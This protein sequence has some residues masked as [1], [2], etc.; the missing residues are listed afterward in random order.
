MK[1][2]VTGAT[3]FVGRHLCQHLRLSQYE[4]VPLDRTTGV[5]IL[6]AEALH[7]FLDDAAPDAIVH[8]AGDADVGGSWRNPRSTFEANAVGTLAVL[9]AARRGTTGRVVVASSA[10]VYGTVIA[11]DLPIGE[12]T[13]LRPTSPYAASKAAAEVVA[14][15]MARSWNCDVVVTRAFN[16]IGPGQSERFVAPSIAMSIARVERDAEARTGFRATN[17]DAPDSGPHAERHASHG[18]RPGRDAPAAV[19]VGNLDARRDLTDVRDV[20][21]AYAALLTAGTRGEVY[22]ICSG[23]DVRIGDL[24]QQLV[25]RARVPVQLSVDPDRF[26]PVDLPVL[27]GDHSRLTAATGWR[28]E[29]PLSSTVDDILD[30]ARRRVDAAAALTDDAPPPPS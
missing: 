25:E 20:V 18:R 11:D 30:D 27:R 28:P 1:V 6:D 5:D 24:A 4:V 12:D 21:R 9:D 7:T 8:L 15:Q 10:D 19:P 13:P 17:V 22:N 16:H 2:L 3:G 29:I 26:R 23:V 14:L